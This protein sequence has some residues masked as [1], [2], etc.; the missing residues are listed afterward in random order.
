MDKSLSMYFGY[1]DFAVVYDI[2]YMKRLAWF[3]VEPLFGAVPMHFSR[4]VCLVALI[5][6]FW[7]AGAGALESSVHCRVVGI[8]DGDTLK[9]LTDAKKEYRVRLAQID[10]PESRQPFGGRSKQQLSELVFGRTVMLKGNLEDRYGR[11]VSQ[12]VLDGLD[13]NKQMVE[14]GMAWVY[15]D[16]SKDASYLQAEG[17]ARQA[18][19]GIW[20]ATNP[21]AP[22]DWRKG[23]R[24]DAQ[25]CSMDGK[26]CPDG[27][28]VGRDGPGCAFVCN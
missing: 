15:R 19:R 12:V 11:L 22:W 4:G 23:A 6:L 1:P 26:Q 3:F 8:S 16:Y 25:V 28:Y 2:Q 10:A 20:S 18:R 7:S 21:V 17:R 5:S 27:R 24:V 14:L 13:I 9:C